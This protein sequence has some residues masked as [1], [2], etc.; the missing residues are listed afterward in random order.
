MTRADIAAVLQQW[1]QGLLTAKQVH[2]WAEDTYMQVELDDWEGDEDYS[3]AN[4]VLGALDMLNLNLMVPE[5][6]P[7]YLDFLR[8]PLGQFAMGS[9]TFQDAIGQ[10]DYIARKK[11]LAADPFYARFCQ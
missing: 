9:A 11:M 8:T 4:E 2:D 10:I 3:V 5:D 1:Q 7:I 6:I